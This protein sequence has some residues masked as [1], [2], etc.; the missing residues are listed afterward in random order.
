MHKITL[1]ETERRY[2]TGHVALEKREGAEN[3]RKI[4]G[5][6]F[7]FNSLSRDLGGFQER[8]APG[9][10]DGVDLS[11]VVALFNH[12]PNLILAR[13][14]AK[15]LLLTPDEIG[16]RYEFDAP[17]T[18]AGNDVYENVSLGNVTGSSFAFRV[19]ETKW[20][21]VGETYI[22][23]IL[24]FK[25]II[26]VSPVVF[27]AYPEAEVGKRSLEEFVKNQEPRN[28][29]QEYREDIDLS[30]AIMESLRN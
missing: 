27:P 13:T 18:T 19:E 24:K 4:V 11:D 12:E 17:N 28:K 2:V 23:N 9:A 10:L 20:E 25:D 16:L 26:D 1:P 14:L 15:T 3:S 7:K 21:E 22:R 5:Y 8:I 30:I 29:N 6:A